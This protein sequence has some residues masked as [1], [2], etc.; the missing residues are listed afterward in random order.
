LD[1]DVANLAI[2]GMRFA[3]LEQNLITA[4]FI[5]SFDFE[6]EDKRGNKMSDVVIMDFN[7]HSA[8]KPKKDHILRVSPRKV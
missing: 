1:H 7:R 6:L 8:H 2:V 3:K 5:A 4:Y